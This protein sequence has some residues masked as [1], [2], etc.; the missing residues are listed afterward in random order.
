MGKSISVFCVAMLVTTPMEL[1]CRMCF[2][3]AGL[4][5]K[6]LVELFFFVWVAAWAPTDRPAG[7]FAQVS[8]TQSVVDPFYNDTSSKGRCRFPAAG[9][10]FPPHTALNEMKKT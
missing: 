8:T 1:V 5:G 10:Q 7:N 4:L 2:N 6:S 9:A 3:L